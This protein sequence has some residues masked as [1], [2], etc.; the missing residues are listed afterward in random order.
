MR[1]P[2]IQFQALNQAYES[3][4]LFKVSLGL[5]LDGLYVRDWNGTPPN[6]IAWFVEADGDSAKLVA[7]EM[8][9]LE[10][11]TKALSLAS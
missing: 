11:E 4:L 9:T 6:P 5:H 8:H 2:P 7:G 1:L 3:K 10:F